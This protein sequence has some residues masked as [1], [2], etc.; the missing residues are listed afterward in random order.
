M[1]SGQGEAR[2]ILNSAGSRTR[3]DALPQ[4]GMWEHRKD[5]DR[6]KRSQ[7]FVPQE[8]VVSA[9]RGPGTSSLLTPG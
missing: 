4:G 6:E 8:F 2:D 3:N 5:G 9:G 7:D 1:H